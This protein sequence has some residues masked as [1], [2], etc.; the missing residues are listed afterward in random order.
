MFVQAMPI[1]RFSGHLPP[2]ALPWPGFYSEAGLDCLSGGEVDG[3]AL[4]WPVINIL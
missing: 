1:C 2:V 3:H 4:Q